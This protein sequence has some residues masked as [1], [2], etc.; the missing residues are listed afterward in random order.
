MLLDAGADY[1]KLT[2]APW[3]NCATNY[4]PGTHHRRSNLVYCL[5]CRK[6]GAAGMTAL[7]IAQFDLEEY[8]D[9]KEM[10]AIVDMLETATIGEWAAAGAGRPKA[11]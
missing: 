5:P 11:E 9:G 4:D 6:R 8:D 2:T 7:E 3:F 10:E 1:D